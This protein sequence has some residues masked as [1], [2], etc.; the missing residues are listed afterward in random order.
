MLFEG[1]TV[2]SEA[3][4]DRLRATGSP[5]PS[6]GAGLDHRR[7]I[8]ARSGA[9]RPCEP[10][11]V[12]YARLIPDRERHYADL[13]RQTLAIPID[14]LVAD[15]LPLFEEEAVRKNLWPQ[16]TDVAPMSAGRENSRPDGGPRPSLP[17]RPRRDT[18]MA[19]SRSTTTAFL[20]RRRRLGTLAGAASWYVRSQHRLP[21]VAFA[22]R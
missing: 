16:P 11:T 12:S 9:R 18:F 15:D 19:E 8:R 7:G 6:R 20:L 17:D 22:R 2:L 14:H 13:G 10:T 21:P 1:F 5:S 4:K 3:G